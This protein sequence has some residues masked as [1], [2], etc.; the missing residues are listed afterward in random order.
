MPWGSIRAGAAVL[1]AAGAP[2]PRRV[3]VT[4]GAGYVGSHIVLALRDAG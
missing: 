1:S 3:L 2:R 4:G